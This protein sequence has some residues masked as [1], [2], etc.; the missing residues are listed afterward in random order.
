M[1][2]TSMD[3]HKVIYENSEKNPIHFITNIS[4]YSSR[5]HVWAKVS[6]VFKNSHYAYIP[7]YMHKALP[8]LGNEKEQ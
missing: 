8:T 3:F 5:R 4:A 6:S 7:T 1:E 2:N